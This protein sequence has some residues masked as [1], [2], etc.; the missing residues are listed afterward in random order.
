MERQTKVIVLMSLA[1]DWNRIVIIGD[2][3]L[4]NLIILE[5]IGSPKIWKIEYCLVKSDES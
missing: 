3:I 5:F 1:T 2:D 4:H